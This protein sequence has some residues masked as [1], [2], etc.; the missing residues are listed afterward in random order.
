MGWT[1][2]SELYDDGGFSGAIIERPAFQRLLV[3]VNDDKIDMVVVYKV[4]RLTRSLSVL[5]QD[6]RNF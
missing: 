5:C 6:R 4:D 3:D 2:L 1:V